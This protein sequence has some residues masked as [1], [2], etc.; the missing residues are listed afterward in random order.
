MS[1]S[2]KRQKRKKGQVPHL[3]TDTAPSE[4]IS[5]G[6][7]YLSS[8]Q[9]AL[10]LP[11]RLNATKFNTL[12]RTATASIKLDDTTRAWMKLWVDVIAQAENPV[13]GLPYQDNASYEIV[14]RLLQR[15]ET[16]CVRLKINPLS[17]AVVGTLQ[18]EGV[19]AFSASFFGTTS[20]V[21]LHHRSLI[22]VWLLVKCVVPIVACPSTDGVLLGKR[23]P[24]E[25]YDPAI[26]R[27]R[28]LISAMRVQRDPAHAPVYFQ[29]PDWAFAHLAQLCARCVELFIVAHEYGHLV[30]ERGDGSFDVP[31][32]A[33][34]SP[35]H[36]EYVADCFGYLIVLRD[37]DEKSPAPW[38][39]APLVFF[40]VLSLMERDGVVP[41]PVDHPS[42]ADRLSSLV[43]MFEHL[44]SNIEL[45]TGA[46]G[47]LFVWNS[48]S[49]LLD[50]G[51]ALATREPVATCAAR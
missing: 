41:P 49:S 42:G 17:A 47:L 20:L 50:D 7:E 24:P 32:A 8:R 12:L 43:T 3:R 9:A 25:H 51:W 48:V 1:K 2:K 6:R 23:S 21:V 5:I 28:E 4:P 22:F 19:N 10:P 33:E 38:A 14:S 35:L 13:S 44:S 11:T 26:E 45:Q 34:P 27:M 37:A 29:P 18:A 40:K 16:A 15:V 39:L 31:P 46:R 36:D 30:V